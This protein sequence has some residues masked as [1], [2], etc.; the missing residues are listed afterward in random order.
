MLLLAHAGITLGVTK[1]LNTAIS[2]NHASTTISPNVRQ[3]L[4]SQSIPAQSSTEARKTPWLLALGN[5]IDVRLLLLGSMLPDIVDKPIGL[6]LFR[7]TFST[8]RLFCHT[9]LFLI[10]ITIAGAY[11]YKVRGRF[12][13]LVLAFGTFIHLILDQMWLSSRTFLWPFLGFAFERE[14]ITDWTGKMLR[15]LYTD[16]SVYLPEFIGAVILVWF[17]LVLVRKKKLGYF[18]KNGK[19]L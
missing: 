12:W 14:D 2:R 7:D 4:P 13:L 16:P 6:Y 9:L 17:V 15:A 19:V 8:G 10:L 11:L 5:R 1:L 3:P 18:L